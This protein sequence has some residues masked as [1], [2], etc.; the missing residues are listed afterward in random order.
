MVTTKF[1]IHFF[2]DK[3]EIFNKYVYPAEVKSTYQKYFTL[4][5]G[6]VCDSGGDE[7]SYWEKNG[8]LIVW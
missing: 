8:D 5:N 7:V 4:W 3:K 1:R 6:K 2:K